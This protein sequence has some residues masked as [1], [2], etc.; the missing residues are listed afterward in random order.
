M[1][2]TRDTFP[3]DL[4]RADLS[5]IVQ[6]L[7]SG[8]FTSEQLVQEYIGR[9]NTIA[10]LEPFELTPQVRSRPT[11]NKVWAFE[12]YLKWCPRATVSFHIGI[13]PV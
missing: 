6:A 4:L 1:V 9:S 10:F 12:P 7:D 11:M 13:A 2:M 8:I 5:G 3:I